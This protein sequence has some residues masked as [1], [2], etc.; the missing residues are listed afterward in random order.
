MYPQ[1]PNQVAWP[2]ARK[3]RGRPFTLAFNLTE[4]LPSAPRAWRG[5]SHQVVNFIHLSLPVNLNCQH[6]KISKHLKM[7]DLDEISYSREETIGAFRHYYRFLV[8]LYMED[9]DI[10]EPPKG[11]WPTVSPEF[12]QLFGKSDEV[13]AL[14]R[15]LSYIRQNSPNGQ[16]SPPHGSANCYWADWQS[17]ADLGGVEA[18]VDMSGL[19]ETLKV[20]TEGAL[21]DVPA[22]VVGLT[23]G[24]RENK[25]FLLDTEIGVVHVC[26]VPFTLRS[27]QHSSLRPH[28][29]LKL[30]LRIY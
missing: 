19:G 26:D 13:I 3:N 14:L 8:D 18:G 23:Y 5:S 30:T 25:T 17:L 1:I 21:D 29:P 16:W 7:P 11:G 9:S 22:H 15:S 2:E 20:M 6:R 27:V 12:G 10:I 24:D 4:D 28:F